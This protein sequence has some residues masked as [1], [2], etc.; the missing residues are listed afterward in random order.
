MTKW[1]YRWAYVRFGTL[2]MSV[3]HLNELGAEGWEAVSAVRQE[4][5]MGRVVL[6][7]KRPK[8]A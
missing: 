2:D 3:D 6:L 7:L 5:K 4:G 8:T 1:E